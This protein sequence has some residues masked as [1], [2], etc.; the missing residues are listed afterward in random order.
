MSPALAALVLRLPPEKK[1]AFFRGFDNL[2]NRTEN[3]YT[4]MVKS[5]VRRT[6]LMVLLALGL[7]G[8]T[9]WQFTQLPTA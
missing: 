2:F 1:N 7:A 9:G 8:I 3:R 4:N 5:L 6:A